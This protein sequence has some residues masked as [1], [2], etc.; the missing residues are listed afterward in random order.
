MA[1]AVEAN[2]SACELP[3]ARMALVLQFCSWSAC[4]MNSTSSARAST[5][6]GWYFGSAGIFHSM[7]MKFS[8]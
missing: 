2:G 7:F 4:R 1:A 5:L 8:V 3:T 6:F